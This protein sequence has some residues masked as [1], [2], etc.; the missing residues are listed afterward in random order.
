MELELMELEF[1]LKCH[2]RTLGMELELHEL[3]FH[4]FFF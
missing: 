2:Y 3:E 1:L 4:I